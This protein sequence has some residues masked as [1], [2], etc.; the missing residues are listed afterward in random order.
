[1]LKFS[2]TLYQKND[3]DYH[4]PMLLGTKY[5]ATALFLPLIGAVNDKQDLRTLYSAVPP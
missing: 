3:K 4:L 1:M 5:L 2:E